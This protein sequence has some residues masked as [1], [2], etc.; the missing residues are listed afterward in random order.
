MTI[1]NPF[2]IHA[3]ENVIV[4]NP[5]KNSWVFEVG[6]NGDLWVDFLQMTADLNVLVN[7]VDENA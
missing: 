4:K 1:S 3:Q 7:L 6:K 5:D 2:L